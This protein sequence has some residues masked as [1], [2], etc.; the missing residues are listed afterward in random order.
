MVV[1][2]LYSSSSRRD[3]APGPVRGVGET[4]QTCKNG[5]P[6]TRHL[7]SLV[8]FGHSRGKELRIL[9]YGFLPGRRTTRKRPPC[10]LFTFSGPRLSPILGSRRELVDTLE[11]VRWTGETWTQRSRHSP[12][13][14]R[15][16]S[17]G[18]LLVHFRGSC[19]G[20][21]SSRTCRKGAHP[22]PTPN[23]CPT[24]T[25]SGKG[26]EEGLLINT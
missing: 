16:D 6:Y 10:K 24:W 21:P 9:H 19:V 23:S 15:H 20:R 1:S 7:L 25:F 22:H 18:T 26:R 11:S 13:R 8:V 17:Q 2:A 4:R 3:D 14:L 5:G 12:L